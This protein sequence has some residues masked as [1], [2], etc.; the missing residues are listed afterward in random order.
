M[1]QRVHLKPEKNPTMFAPE[2]KEAIVLHRQ[3]FGR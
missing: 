3:S 1:H 2:I